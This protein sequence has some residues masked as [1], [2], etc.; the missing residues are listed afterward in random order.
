MRVTFVL[1]TVVLLNACV[2]TVGGEQPGDSSWR[3]VYANDANG[4]P[5]SGSKAALID[6]VRAGKPIR[7]YT[8]GRRIEHAADAQFLSIFEGEVFA[9]LT[10][11]ESQRPQ[12]EPLGM[13]FREPGVKWRSIVGSNGFV[14]AYMDGNEP[15]VRTGRTRWFARD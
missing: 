11:I 14:T 8:A 6:A 5:V 12:L 15:N 4:E 13:L 1:L 10:P 9:Q 7:V 3:V 2:T